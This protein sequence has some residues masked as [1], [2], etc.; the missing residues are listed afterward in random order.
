MDVL[1]VSDDSAPEERELITRVL[2]RH[3][4]GLRRAGSYKKAIEELAHDR[5]RIMI[6]YDFV[7]EK[8]FSISESVRIMKEI[9]PSSLII[10]ISQETRLETERELRRSGLYFHLASPFDESELSEV[11]SAAIARASARDDR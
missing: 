8:D 1:L 2:E 6:L 3:D 7:S 11:L 10:S 5:Y 9:S 4:V